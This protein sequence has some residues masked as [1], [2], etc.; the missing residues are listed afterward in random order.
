MQAPLAHCIA[1][2][3][4]KDESACVGKLLDRRAKKDGR[5]PGCKVAMNTMFFCHEQILPQISKHVIIKSSHHYF[6][7][8]RTVG[9]L[10][11]DI[12]GAI[13]L[14]IRSIDCSGGRSRAALK[15]NDQAVQL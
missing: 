1:R 10:P 14:E 8:R 15:L 4:I 7:P 13:W 6:L 3:S 11:F 12:L 2:G 5:L 9:V